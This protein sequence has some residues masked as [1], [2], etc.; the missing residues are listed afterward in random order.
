MNFTPEFVILCVS[1][2]SVL[3][4]VWVWPDVKAKGTLVRSVFVLGVVATIATNIVQYVFAVN[5]KARGRKEAENASAIALYA[6]EDKNPDLLKAI[7]PKSYLMGYRHFRHHE[8]DEALPYFNEC[9]RRETFVAPSLYLLAY[10]E[11]H[12]SDFSLRTDVDYA[13]ALAD[14]DLALKDFPDYAPALY[15]KALLL[16]NSRQIEPA[17]QALSQAV[18]IDR[19][20]YIPAQDINDPGE[21]RTFFAPLAGQD[22]F[23]RLQK[24]CREFQGLSVK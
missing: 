2:V 23:V 18:F 9:I 17:F 20:G 19:Y 15:L 6:F 21:V 24:E 14:L 13:P 16:V 7:A 4:G 22:R 8:F 5:N 1:L 10:M 11:T 3:T 12:N